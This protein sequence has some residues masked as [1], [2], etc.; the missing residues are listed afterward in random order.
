MN[1]VKFELGNVVAT[2]GVRQAIEEAGQRSR[3]FLELHA[4]RRGG[5]TGA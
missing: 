3:Q 5:G 4:Q 1:K 2:P